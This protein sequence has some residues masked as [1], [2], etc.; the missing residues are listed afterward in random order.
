MQYNLCVAIITMVLWIVR[1]CIRGHTL[2]MYGTV[3]SNVLYDVILIALWSYSA[4]TQSPGH[5]LELEYLYPRQRYSY[6]KYNEIGPQNLGTCETA[7]ASFGLVIFAL[8][9]HTLST[10]HTVEANL[11]SSCSV[12]FGIRCLSTCMYVAYTY[13][14]SFQETDFLPCNNEKA[15]G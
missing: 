14:R 7:K 5:Y 12:W 6:H 9:V 10:Q 8:C 13:G 11:V 2:D 1:L 4:V 3:I 15:F